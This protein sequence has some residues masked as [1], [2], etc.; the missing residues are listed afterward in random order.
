[1]MQDNAKPKVDV[2]CETDKFRGFLS[3]VIS[4]EPDYIMSSEKPRV[5]YYDEAENAISIHDLSS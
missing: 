5:H 4:F 3:D 2:K 1:M